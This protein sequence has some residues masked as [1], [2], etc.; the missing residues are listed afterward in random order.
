M[1]RYEAEVIPGLLQSP[2]YAKSIISLGPAELSP[3][4]VE[5]RVAIRMQRQRI[6]TRQKP[7]A[8]HLDVILSESTLIRGFTPEIMTDQ[9]TR[10][11]ATS[12]LPNVSIRVIPFSAGAHTAY[13][14]PF[15]ILDFPKESPARDAEPTTIYQESPTGSLYL[16]KPSEVETYSSMWADLDR[17]AFDEAASR[18]LI[19]QRV[20]EWS[21]P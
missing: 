15:V 7:T 13:Q 18:A 1:R 3:E 12:E 17:L 4:E 9:L 10:L 14:G 16:D 2:M 19:T 11:V 5:E 8:P 6:L 20:G 21:Q